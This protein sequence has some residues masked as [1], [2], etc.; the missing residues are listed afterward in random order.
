MSRH[1]CLLPPKCT[2]E[3]INNTEEIIQDTSKNQFKLGDNLLH[4]Q[5]EKK[6]SQNPKL[7]KQ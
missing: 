3:T 1:S 7:K 5:F 4:R 2:Q 6:L